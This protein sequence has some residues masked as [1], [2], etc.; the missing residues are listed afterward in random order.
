[1]KTRFL[2]IK[3]LIALFAFSNAYGQAQPPDQ[4]LQTNLQKANAGDPAAMNLLGNLYANG[5]NGVSKNLAEAKKWYQAAADKGYPAGN[6]NM[7]LLYERGEIVAKDMAKAL[8]YF[9]LAADGGL[10]AAQKK[11]AALAQ[12]QS[13]DRSSPGLVCF[14]MDSKDT[15]WATGGKNITS[16]DPII[17]GRQI[18]EEYGSVMIWQFKSDKEILRSTVTS[19]KM[20]SVG[21]KNSFIT[22]SYERVGNRI[23]ENIGG[24]K[25]TVEIIGDTPQALTVKTI[26]AAGNCVD[27][28]R[29]ATEQLA[30]KP[31]I[32]YLKIKG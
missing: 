30:K 28:V 24:C 21:S 32:V 5:S 17:I 9:K 16:C 3:C 2:F 22:N 10:P 27:A 25:Q 29:H 31:P 14:V 11:I 15:R 19:T 8:G 18:T 7:G 13:D 20:K 12:T 26:G 4:F 6:F 1:M 23:T